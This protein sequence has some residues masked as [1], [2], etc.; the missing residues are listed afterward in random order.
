MNRK[1]LY[2]LSISINILH[3]TEFPLIVDFEQ[4]MRCID[5]TP[6]NNASAWE[7]YKRNYKS[8]IIRTKHAQEASYKIPPVIHFIWLGSELPKKFIPFIESWRQHHQ[9]WLI[10]IWTEKEAQ[11]LTLKNRALF[12]SNTNHGYRSDIL[13]YEILWQEGGLY[14]DIDFFCT[15]SVDILHR[16]FSFYGCL[17]PHQTIIANGII[18]AAPHHP[19]MLQCIEQIR[20]LTTQEGDSHHTEIQQV[21]GPH[22]VTRSVWNF[23]QHNPRHKEILILPAG[24]FFAVPVTCKNQGNHATVELQMLAKQYRRPESLALHCW[25]NS[26]VS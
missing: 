13:R 20:A 12:D 8:L 24:Y 14:V 10:K 21:S 9:K 6:S 26:W 5:F 18:G 2:I 4:S 7:Y 19:I 11:Q 23:V 17:F 3:A 15:H 16:S 25:A 1:I 22:N